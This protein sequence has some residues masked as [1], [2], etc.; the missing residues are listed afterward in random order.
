MR[1]CAPPL[2]ESGWRLDS[3]GFTADDWFG[4]LKEYPL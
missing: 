1:R 4:I 3:P 2:N